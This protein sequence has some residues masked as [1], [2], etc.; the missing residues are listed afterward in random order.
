MCLLFC[1]CGGGPGVVFS[2][3]HIL[4]LV[5][6]SVAAL[7][8]DVEAFRWMGRAVSLSQFRLPRIRVFLGGISLGL[9]YWRACMVLFRWIR[10]LLEF[11]F[12]L[13]PSI[14]LLLEIPDI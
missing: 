4:F 11:F 8:F 6:L 2:C 12:F 5:V 13:C 1:Y 10:S 14:H 7:F 9:V 3:F